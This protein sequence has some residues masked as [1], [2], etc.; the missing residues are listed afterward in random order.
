MCNLIQSCFAD[1]VI[2]ID[3]NRTNIVLIPKV[4]NPEFITQ[5]CPIGLCNVFYKLISK[6]IVN[7]IRSLLDNIISPFQASFIPGRQTTDNVIICQE[8][9][10]TLRNNKASNGG[11]VWK[12]DFDKA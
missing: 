10:H 8:V 11:M 3:M 7:R 12:I 4:D 6:I 5:F 2:P 9:I 1:R